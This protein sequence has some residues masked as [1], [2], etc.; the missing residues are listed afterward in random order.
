MLNPEHS[1]L[2]STSRYLPRMVNMLVKFY[3]PCDAARDVPGAALL[4]A[5]VKQPL[6]ARG[7]MC[8]RRSLAEEAKNRR[9]RCE[10]VSGRE[11]VGT[12]PACS[13]ERLRGV[14]CSCSLPPVPCLAAGSSRRSQLV[15][16]DGSQ[17]DPSHLRAPN[18]AASCSANT[19]GPAEVAR[20]VSQFRLGGK[21]S[22]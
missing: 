7:W 17:L 12:S 21:P 19:I 3:I 6:L 13:R 2:L 14:C 20:S 5:G 4:A 10:P 1:P 18:P 11:E 8:A 15:R 16:A 9:T 22:T